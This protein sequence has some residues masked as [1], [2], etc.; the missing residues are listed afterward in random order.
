MLGP[1]N[2]GTRASSA[3]AAVQ[4]P[5]PTPSQSTAEIAFRWLEELEAEVSELRSRLDCPRCSI[6][7]PPE[8]R[9]PGDRW[10]QDIRPPHTCGRIS[11][12]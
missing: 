3:R 7:E 10:A 1:E 11:G 8:P 2:D 4:T 6:P 12:T 9:W 5:T